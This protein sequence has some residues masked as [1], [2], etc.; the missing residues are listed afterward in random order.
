MVILCFWQ[1]GW[2]NYKTRELTR[3]VII[4]SNLDKDHKLRYFMN[5]KEKKDEIKVIHK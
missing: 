1:S 2:Q 5:K 3:G 4:C